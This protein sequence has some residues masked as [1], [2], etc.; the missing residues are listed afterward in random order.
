ME[1]EKY[2]G[3]T[4][5]EILL[6]L[7]NE[8]YHASH[9][10]RERSLKFAMWILGFI[11]LSTPW[12]LLN[13]QMLNSNIKWVFSIIIIIAAIFSFWY[14]RAIH[15]GFNSNQKVLIDI[16]EILGCY[17]KGLYIDSKQLFPD[18]YKRI[19]RFSLKNHFFTIYSLIGVGVSIIIVLIWFNPN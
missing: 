2:D 12:L 15:I 19:K 9:Q 1:L 17:E 13:R 6:D 5:I 16:E 10:M 14:L 11:I 3:K 8:R 4:K 18:E 7:L